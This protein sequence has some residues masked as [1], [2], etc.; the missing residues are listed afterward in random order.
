MAGSTVRGPVLPLQPPRLLSET[1]KNFLVSMG[2][3]GPMQV[4]HQPG[5]ASSGEW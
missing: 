1:T 3:P 2:L 4:S 5:L